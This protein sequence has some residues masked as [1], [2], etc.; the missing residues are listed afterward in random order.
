M[1]ELYYTRRVNKKIGLALV[2]LKNKVVYASRNLFSREAKRLFNPK[3][4]I[5][6]KIRRG[7]AKIVKRVK[8]MI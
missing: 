6:E 8:A 7:L 3:L 2:D 5:T 4:R 1:Q